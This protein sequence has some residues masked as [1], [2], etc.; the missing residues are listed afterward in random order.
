MEYSEDQ[1]TLRSWMPLI[2]ANRKTDEP[3]AATKVTYGTDVDFGALT[4]G[5]IAHLSTKENFDL[6][7]NQNV[8]R[9][10]QDKRSVWHVS[11]QDRTSK[12]S[13]TIKANFVFLGAGGGGFLMLYVPYTYQYRVR[14][15]LTSVGMKEYMFKFS[16]KG[17][18]VIVN[19]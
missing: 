13:H 8:R 12:K 9:I 1:A 11:V 10:K 16:D 19:D 7:L 3:I 4:R 14:H 17:S 2:M 5:L 6:S 18:E 15:A